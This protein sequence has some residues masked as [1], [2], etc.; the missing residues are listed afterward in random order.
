M[1]LSFLTC[2][3]EIFNYGKKCLR[4]LL[5]NIANRITIC[6]MKTENC[7][8]NITLNKITQKLYETFPSYRCIEK[9]M[10]CYFDDQ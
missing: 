5:Q 10:I 1:Q 8:D 3:P 2:Y 9:T 6:K 4:K 7:R